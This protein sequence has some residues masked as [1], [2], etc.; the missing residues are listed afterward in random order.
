MLA[1]VTHPYHR[2]GVT[3]WIKDAFLECK[4]KGISA[5]LVT[6][7]PSKPFISGKGR[8]SMVEF[9]SMKDGLYAGRADFRFE[10]GLFDARV[11]VYQTLIRKN[12]PEGSVLI[13]S[14]DDAC[15][16]A[17]CSLADLYSVVGVLHADD[18]HYYQLHKE[19]G[20]YLAGVV[21]VSNRILKS[22]SPVLIPASVIPCGINMDHFQ[23]GVKH[24]RILWVGRVE[25][26]QKRVSDVVKVCEQ[27]LKTHP[28]WTVEVYGHGDRLPWLENEKTRLGLANLILHGWQDAATIAN[29]M[30]HASIL[31]QTSNYEGMSVA[32]MEAL[33]SGCAI[34]S[35]RVSGIEDL[36]FAESATGLVRL[37]EVGAVSE[38]VS[39]LESVIQNW[40]PTVASKAREVALNHFSISNCVASYQSFTV[41][42]KPCSKAL[43]FRFSAAKRMGSFLVAIMRLIK[44]NLTK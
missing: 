43:P 7:A 1:F 20:D 25:E 9:V 21:G 11:R 30:S 32:V 26:E 17:C 24:K 12:I 42:L 15:W 37:Y 14:D 16:V 18:P 3:S 2:G 40:Q 4:Q 6:V 41:H 29:A 39:Q 22:A 19:F 34:V 31:L 27:L 36:E 23:P 35:S 13:P 38:A 33:A 28:E 8:P 10:L 5:A 44:Y